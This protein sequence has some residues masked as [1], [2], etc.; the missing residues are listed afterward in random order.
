MSLMLSYER[1]GV[2]MLNVILLITLM[3]SVVKQ[4]VIM[5]TVIMLSVIFLS[6]YLS[7]GHLLR[8]VLSIA[9]K[10]DVFVPNINMLMLILFMP[11]VVKQSVIMLNVIC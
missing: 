9:V 4:S 8:V 2:T 5:L 10:Q 11:S 6:F 3:P 1:D 7:K